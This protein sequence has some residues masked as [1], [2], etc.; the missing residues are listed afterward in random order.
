MIERPHLE[1]II[2]TAVS[3]GP[4]RVAV[5]YPCSA[6]SIE[7]TVTAQRMGLIEP[8]MIGPRRRIQSMLE[9]FVITVVLGL[10]IAA[11]LGVAIGTVVVR[12]QHALRS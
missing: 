1:K 12:L 6:S 5:A 3:L 9:L 11:V 8:T 7:A 10:V 4:A 2:K